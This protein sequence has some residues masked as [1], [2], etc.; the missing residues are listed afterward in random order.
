M[1][2]V[3]DNARRSLASD[4]L[5]G[6]IP[7]GEGWPGRARHITSSYR[8][9]ILA[10][11]GNKACPAEVNVALP[12]LTYLSRF[13]CRDGTGN[14]A[15]GGSLF[16]AVPGFHRTQSGTVQRG[17]GVWR[18]MLCMGRYWFP[19]ISWMSG[20]L[21]LRQPNSYFTLSPSAASA[22]PQRCCTISQRRLQSR[23]IRRSKYIGGRV[24]QV[25]VNCRVGGAGPLHRAI[26]A[27]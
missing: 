25:Q 5:A 17:G 8:L 18:A 7:N 13:F 9:A 14:Q 11:A 4:R 6:P 24:M 27:G 16:N 2:R 19:D 21:Q 26:I 1:S 22:R 3:P 12:H 23:Q 15:A 10:G 20:T